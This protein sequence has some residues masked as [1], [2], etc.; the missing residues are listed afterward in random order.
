VSKAVADTLA[1]VSGEFESEVMADLEG[2]R[3]E[4]LAKIESVRKEAAGNVSKILETGEKQAESVGRQIIGAAELEAR[5]GQL[6]SLE[7]AVNKAFDS[8]TKKISDSAGASYEKAMGKLIQEGLDIIG[9]RAS[10]QCSARDRKTVTSALKKLDDKAKVSFDE[11]PIETIG[12]VVLATPDGTIRFDNTFE[13]RLE[14]MKPTLRKD[15][16]YILTGAP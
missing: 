9:P 2:W 10:I 1:K 6:R 7:I 11:D 4:A 3:A 5:N 15:I 14:R 8:A 12:G 13:A 16:A